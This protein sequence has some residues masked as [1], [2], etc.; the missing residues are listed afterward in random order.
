MSEGFN[1][2]RARLHQAILSA[3]DAGHR[4]ET[5]ITAMVQRAH[6]RMDAAAHRLS[7]GQLRARVAAAGTRFDRARSARDSRIAAKLETASMRLGLAAAALDAMSPLAVLERGYA[8]AQDAN[9]RV[10]RQAN[11]VSAGDTL[12]LRLW[13]GALNCRVDQVEEGVD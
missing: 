10:V 3:D 5:V 7:P 8:I 2:V 13:K 1:Q 6:R 12:R 4:L 11:A 9:G